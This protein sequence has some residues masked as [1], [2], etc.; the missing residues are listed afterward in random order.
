MENYEFSPVDIDGIEHAAILESDSIDR[1]LLVPGRRLL[2]FARQEAAQESTRTWFTALKEN[3]L[4]PAKTENICTVTV[5]AEAMGHNLPAALGSVLGQSSYRGDNFIGASRFAMNGQA[6]DAYTPFDAKVNYLR[7]HSPAPVWCVLD[8]I[9][10]G[11][12]LVRVLETAFANGQPPEKILFGTPAGSATGV[13]KVASLCRQHGIEL[14]A[15]FFGAAFGLW[16]DGTGLPWCH[17]DTL[18]SGTKR[19]QT[20]KQTAARLF[21]NLPGFC[22]VGDC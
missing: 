19:S 5:L 17:P 18:L 1:L 6:S 14:H 13:R 9:A 12:T 11:A 4:L 22:A 21:N 20:N 2:G 7:L 10:T 16:H 8:T 3:K 15:T